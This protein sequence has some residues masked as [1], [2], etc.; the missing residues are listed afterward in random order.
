MTEE[1]VSQASLERAR[2]EAAREL[3]KH[4]IECARR[5]GA[6][7]SSLDKLD[8]LQQ[9]NTRLLYVILAGMLAVVTRSFWPALFGG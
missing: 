1:K 8:A 9:R 4:E 3:A 6:I 7:N 5:Y 2:A